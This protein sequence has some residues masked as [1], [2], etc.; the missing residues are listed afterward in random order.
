MSNSSNLRVAK[1]SGVKLSKKQKALLEANDRYIDPVN[2]KERHE[3]CKVVNVYEAGYLDPKN[4]KKW[5]LVMLFDTFKHTNLTCTSAS[6]EA[7]NLKLVW[8]WQ[9]LTSTEPHAFLSHVAIN[10][11]KTCVANFY[12]P[13][14]ASSSAGIELSAVQSNCCLRYVR[15]ET[16]WTFVI[17]VRDFLLSMEYT[18]QQQQL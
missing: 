13:T 7:D 6:A 15:K 18:K 8:N 5:K 3:R 14:T 12:V 1:K 16:R 9:G 2:I 11:G 4:L 17:N 10:W